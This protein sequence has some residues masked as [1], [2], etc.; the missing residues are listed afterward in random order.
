[1]NHGLG[2]AVYGLYSSLKENA[3]NDPSSVLIDPFQANTKIKIVIRY[4]DVG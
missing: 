1:M 2:K 3:L 4:A